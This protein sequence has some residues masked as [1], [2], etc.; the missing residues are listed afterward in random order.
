MADFTW[1]WPRIEADLERAVS[2]QGI[3]PAAVFLENRAKEIT[4]VPAPRK[5]VVSRRGVSYY[6][7]LTKATPG[8]PPRKLSGRGRASIT[9]EMVNPLL[10]RVGTNAVHMAAHERGGLHKWLSVA[11]EK[12][13]GAL[14]RIVGSVEVR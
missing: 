2:K 4:S 6:R 10:A 11:A 9:H 12:F 8:A 14:A 3:E 1:N 13:R 5:R 7:A